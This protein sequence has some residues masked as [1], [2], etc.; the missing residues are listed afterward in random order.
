[1][2]AGKLLT[3]FTAVAVA[4]TVGISYAA[5]DVTKT[6]KTATIAISK[7]MKVEVQ[8]ITAVT[9]QL[10]PAGTFAVTNGEAKD[11]ISVPFA[12]TIPADF[13]GKADIKLAVDDVKDD[14]DTSVKELFTFAF[15]KGTGEAATDLSTATDTAA[16]ASNQYVLVVTITKDKDTITDGEIAQIAGKSLTFTV[17]AEAVAKAAA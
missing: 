17:S 1:M 4:A 10:A 7:Q 2:K 9:D 14:T 3:L 5:W 13:V 12:V 6:E 8:D 15:K 16:G 11:S